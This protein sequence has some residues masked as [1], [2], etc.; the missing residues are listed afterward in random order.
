[1]SVLAASLHFVSVHGNSFVL[2]S[3]ISATDKRG[4]EKLKT[5]RFS[6]SN[7]QKPNSN[8]EEKLAAL[9]N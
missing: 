2:C 7:R 5:Q 3:K 1:M 4:N 8:T 9:E 6:S